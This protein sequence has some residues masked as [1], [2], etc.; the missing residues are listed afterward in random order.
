MQK[1]GNLFIISAPSGAG[2][3][4]LVRWLT[5]NIPNLTVSVSHTTRPRRPSEEDARDYHFI[6]EETFRSLI[7]DDRFLEHARVFDHYYGT[8]RPWVEQQL[9]DGRDIILEID[10]QGAQQVR[11]R[12]PDA[13][14]VFILPPSCETLQA[15]LQ[16]RGDNNDTV[17]RRMDEAVAE[18]SHYREYDYL[19]IND[20]L[21]TARQDLAAIVRATRQGY[22]RQQAYY[23]EFMGQILSG[24][25]KIK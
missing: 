6:D 1:Q 13:V 10:W 24:K 21:D 7:A 19:V 14:G 16:K 17:R 18:L 9:A 8:S 5:E 3:T 20:D 11:G 15:R 22:R 12:R 23:D 2:K 25:T 4:T